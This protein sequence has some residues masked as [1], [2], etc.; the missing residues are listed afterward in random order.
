MMQVDVENAFNNIFQTIIFKELCKVEEPLA[1]IVPFTKL[2]Y[3]AHSFFT[4][5]MGDMC[6][7]SSLL[8]HF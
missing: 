8:N 2:F 4:T 6:R 3:G 5:N 1:S 7:R